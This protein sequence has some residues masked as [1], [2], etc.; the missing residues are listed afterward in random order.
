M[1]PNSTL[2]RKE[3]THA[4]ALSIAVAVEYYLQFVPCSIRGDP[5]K[6]K[7]QTGLSILSSFYS[8]HYSYSFIARNQQRGYGIVRCSYCVILT[9]QRRK[10][11]TPLVRRSVVELSYPVKRMV[12]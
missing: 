8:T 12:R 10:E 11:L 6:A 5:Q 7:D 3:Q 2:L 1:R 9:V 4:T